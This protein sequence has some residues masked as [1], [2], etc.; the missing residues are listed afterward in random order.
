[1]VA[2]HDRE[3]RLRAM[4]PIF[5]DSYERYYVYNF[6]KMCRTLYI[7]LEGG[8]KVKAGFM[9]G[10]QPSTMALDIADK[11]RMGYTEYN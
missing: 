11:K 10:F 8:Y 1:M 7:A 6:D 9:R 2:K 4:P 3:L 5:G